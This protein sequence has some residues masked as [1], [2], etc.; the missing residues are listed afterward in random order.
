MSNPCGGASSPARPSGPCC[1][2]LSPCLQLEQLERAAEQARE[3][4]V[5]AKAVLAAAEKAG[6]EGVLLSNREL[7]AVA[8]AAIS[9]AEERAAPTRGGFALFGRPADPAAVEEEEEEEQVAIKRAP[10]PLFGGLFGKPATK[11]VEEEEEEEEEAPVEE[12]KAAPSKVRHM[13]SFPTFHIEGCR[14][15]G[16][17][18]CV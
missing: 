14:G 12:E 8:R 7:Q 11:A 5:A 10:V 9:P 4:E 2:D 6:R 17:R 13:G 3:Q 18:S 1:C 15:F 16:P